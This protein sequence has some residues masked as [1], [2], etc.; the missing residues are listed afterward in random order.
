MHGVVRI[1]AGF[2]N[3]TISGGLSVSRMFPFGLGPFTF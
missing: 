2:A 3:P 1:G